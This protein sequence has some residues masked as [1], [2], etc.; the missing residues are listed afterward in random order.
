MQL[1][2]IELLR[3]FAKGAI[4]ATVVQQLAAA[5]WADGWG[6]DDELAEALKS[7]GG[8]RGRTHTVGRLFKG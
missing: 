7:A 2:A 6:R 3:L 4:P 5:A 1:L 8:R